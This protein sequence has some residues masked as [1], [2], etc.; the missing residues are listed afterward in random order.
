[1]HE[2]C[3]AASPAVAMSTTRAT[4]AERSRSFI[5]RR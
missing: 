4:S 1:V 3:A 2:P 5:G